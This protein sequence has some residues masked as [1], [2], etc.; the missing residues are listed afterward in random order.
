MIRDKSPQAIVETSN[1]AIKPPRL[2]AL[3]VPARSMWKRLPRTPIA[4]VGDALTN[5]EQTT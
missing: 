3:I 4:V 5:N 1:P 2:K